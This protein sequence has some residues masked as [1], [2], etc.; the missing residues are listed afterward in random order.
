LLAAACTSSGGGGASI[1]LHP[2]GPPMVRQVLMT[3]RVTDASGSSTSTRI[4][5]NQLAFGDHPDIPR[6]GE[7][8][9]SLFNLPEDDR[10]VTAA[11]A[12]NTQKLRVVFDELLLGNAIE[13]LACADGSYSRVPVGT[14]PDDIAA[15]SP[16]NL[17]RCHKVCVGDQGPIGL[18]D[19]DEDGA[20]DDSRMIEV[21]P[22][23]LVAGIECEGVNIPLDRDRSFYQPSGNQQIPAGQL[24][25]GLG[26]AL[27][28]APLAGLRTSSTCRLKLHE[29]VVDKDGIQ[30]CAPPDGD[31]TQGCSPGD[32]GLIE[33]S[34]EPLRLLG[35]SPF[36]GAMNVPL[37]A[38]QKN[39]AAIQ[40]MF[41]ARIGMDG[42]ASAITLR[43]GG[44]LVPITVA[45]STQD[46]LVEIQ[47]PG[48]Y[49]PQTE[50]VLTIAGGA[51]GLADLYGGR[52]PAAVE[53]RFT[54]AAMTVNG[55]AGVGGDAS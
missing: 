8:G 29:S 38:S 16:P 45:A 17:S 43:T 11:L 40:L 49:Q 15:C 46:A 9:S 50:Y 22:D 26:P 23:V 48:G 35:S 18:L 37:L 7:G 19:E 10:Q 53:I 24:L 54:T 47:V 20:A 32:L 2:E 5:A 34:V 3:E 21:A 33:F 44:N 42:L 55:D 12:S 27:V 28:L 6:P 31:I 14:T 39:Y 13:E 51:S 4:A 30:A 25:D 41:N 52:L 36:S 1:K